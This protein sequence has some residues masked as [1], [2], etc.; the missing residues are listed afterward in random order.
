MDNF[1]KSGFMFISVAKLNLN[2]EM[3]ISASGLSVCLFFTKRFSSCSYLETWFN[4]KKGLSFS[5]NQD[6]DKGLHGFLAMAKSQ[7]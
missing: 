3:S 1:F 4:R 6:M 2:E 5:L 7:L